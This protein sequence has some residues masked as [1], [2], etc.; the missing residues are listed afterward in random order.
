MALYTGPKVL[1]I[2]LQGEPIGLRVVPVGRSTSH[3]TAKA[4]AEH[5]GRLVQLHT[6]VPF[7]ISASNAQF[8]F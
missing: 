6:K 1:P 5:T 8:F 4:I 7:E 3:T 2:G